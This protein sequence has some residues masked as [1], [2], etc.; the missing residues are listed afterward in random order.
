MPASSGVFYV[1]E[2]KMIERRPTNKV[3]ERKRIAML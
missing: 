2:D 1:P 3:I